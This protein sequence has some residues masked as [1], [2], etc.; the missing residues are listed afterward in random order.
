[1]L[2]GRGYFEVGE[3]QNNDKNIINTQRFFNQVS[4]EEFQGLDFV[5]VVVDKQIKKHGQRDPDARPSQCF[6]H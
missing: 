1:M 6:P 4:G 5:E 2:I 3:Y